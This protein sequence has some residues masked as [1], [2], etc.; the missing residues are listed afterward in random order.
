MKV[1]L[2]DLSH[3]SSSNHVV[4]LNDECMVKF[5]KL[6]RR[7]GGGNSNVSP[8][9]RQS[10]FNNDKMQTILFEGTF[11][12]NADVKNEV[13]P[14]VKNENNF[15]SI[16]SWQNDVKI[17]VGLTVS[18]MGLRFPCSVVHDRIAVI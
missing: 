14:T 7:S 3:L 11:E 4:R 13:I 10:E 12:L 2:G 15:E 8:T 6:R 17:N 16:S 9:K 5:Y 1:T 18:Y